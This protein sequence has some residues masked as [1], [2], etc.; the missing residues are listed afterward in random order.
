MADVNPTPPVCDL[1][2]KPAL[3]ACHQGVWCLTHAPTAQVCRVCKGPVVCRTVHIVRCIGWEFYW[4][5]GWC[6]HHEPEADCD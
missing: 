5:D 6:E 1:C 4:A 2:S 3:V